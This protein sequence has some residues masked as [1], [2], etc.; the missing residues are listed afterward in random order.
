MMAQSRGA[1]L[2]AGAGLLVLV[3][4]LRRAVWPAVLTIAVTVGAYIV[5]LLRLDAE[6]KLIERGSAGRVAI[7]QWFLDRTTI[8]DTIIGR[9]MSADVTIAEEELGWFV[10][11]PHSAYLTQF[12]LTGVLGLGILL[13]VIGWATRCALVQAKRKEALWLALIASG[14]M[15]LLFDCGQMFSLYSAPRIEFLLLLVPAALLMGRAA[16]EE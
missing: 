15:A 5:V 3:Y 8:L 7:Y 10:D 12:I 16:A 11:H 14:S 1:M 9:G 13:F 4:Y 2:A 6:V